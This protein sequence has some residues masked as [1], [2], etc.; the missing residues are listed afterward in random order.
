[1]RASL[2]IKLP[3][4]TKKG[5]DVSEAKACA[6]TLGLSVRGVGGEHTEAGE[7]GTVDISPSA[8]LCIKESEIVAALYKGI[9]LLMEK[10]KAAETAV[11]DACE[12]DVAA[13]H[14]VVVPDIDIGQAMM[15]ILDVKESRPENRMAKHFDLA[16]LK[17]LS[18]DQQKFLL[19]CCKSGYENPD[20]G[21]G[22]YAM[23][24]TDY[25]EFKVYF[26]KVI[27]DYHGIEG[28]AKHVNCWDL[29]KVE[30]LPK[31]G[32]LC[33]K[34]LGLG[35]TSMRV[36]VGRNLKAFPLPGNM[37]REDRV[38][39]EARMITAFEKLMA[40]PAYGGTYYTL[41][42]GTKYSIDQAKYSQLVDAHIMFQDMSLDPYLIS[43]GLSND[44]PYGRG[45]YASADKGFIVWVGEE[46]H[47]CIMCIKTGT[48]LNDV[49]DRLEVCLKMM[50]SQEGCVFAHSPDYGYVTSCP[51]NLGSG[52]RASVHI[53]LSCLTKK[54]TDIKEAEAFA[55]TLGLAVRGIGG[56]HTEAGKDGTVDISPTAR[57]CIKESEIVASLYKGIA[58]LRTHEVIKKY[59]SNFPPPLPTC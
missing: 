30:G 45:A 59:A 36:R 1:M 6:K 18:E 42:P 23:N 19:L 27:R 51:T 37:T 57:L 5:K 25:D 10:E 39:L 33:L 21:M 28:D 16:Y 29:S 17:S 31:G 2:H 34:E 53:K 15:S 22:L 55:Q 24:P 50:E 8:R 11:G 38:N 14:K 48:I 44:W 20:S 49:F 47:L 41:T 26:D 56:E 4:L 7:D 13:P 52:M 54:G 43:A 35:D 9:K 32:L 3:C 46:D 58:L 40:D 12:G